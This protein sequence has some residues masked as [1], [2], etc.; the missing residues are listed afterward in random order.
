MIR[1][2][3]IFNT[4]SINHTLLFSTGNPYR[5]SRNNFENIY[6]TYQFN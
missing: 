1:K 2:M 5:E 3:Y 4:F 6:K